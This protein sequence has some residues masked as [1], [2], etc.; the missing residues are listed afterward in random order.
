MEHLGQV[1]SAALLLAALCL[2][3][4]AEAKAYGGTRHYALDV[5]KAKVGSFAPHL[6]S[7]LAGRNGQALVA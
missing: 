6:A 7:W 3:P 4:L 1:C 5:Q 2:A